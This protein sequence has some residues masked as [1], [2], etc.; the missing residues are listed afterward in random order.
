[1][2]GAALSAFRFPQIL[3]ID[4]FDD[5]ILRVAMLRDSV[6]GVVALSFLDRRAG[7]RALAGDRLLLVTAPVEGSGGL[8]ANAHRLRLG[9]LRQGEF[10][11]SVL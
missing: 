9:H 2:L 3:V 7:E 8:R 1:M 5:A 10:Q 11:D 4:R 6:E